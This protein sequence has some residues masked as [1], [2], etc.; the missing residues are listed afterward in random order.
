VHATLRAEGCRVG[1]NR[2]AR[3]MRHHGIQGRHKRRVPRTTDSKHSLPLVLN[4]L[5]RQFTTPAPNR[6]WLADI[7]Y[8]PTNG[9]YHL[10]SDQ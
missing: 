5:D 10:C 2:V 1:V 7:T 3:L 8:V 4:L 9:R 6:V